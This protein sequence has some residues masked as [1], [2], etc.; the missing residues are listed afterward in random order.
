MEIDRQETETSGRYVVVL[1]QSSE[2]Y[3][4][5]IKQS[6]DTIVIDHTFVPPKFRGRGIAAKLAKKAFEDA[7]NEGKRIVPQCPYIAA[8][9]RRNP[10]LQGL[11]A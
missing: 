9:I 4:T 8:L 5:F 10:D 3:L 2:A 11:S 6:S 7:K 1:E